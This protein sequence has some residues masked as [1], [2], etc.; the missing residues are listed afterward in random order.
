M[1]ACCHIRY[2]DNNGLSPFIRVALIMTFL[3]SNRTLTK[4]SWDRL[5]L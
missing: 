4:T 3:Y 5:S 1:P 2:H